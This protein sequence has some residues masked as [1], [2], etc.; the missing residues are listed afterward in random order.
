[1]G[2]VLPRPSEEAV[3]Q[4]VEHLANEP[5]MSDEE[6]AEWTADWTAIEQE[7]RYRDHADDVAE[8]RA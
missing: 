6:L 8:G 7:M 5:M 1:M 2:Q 4:F 3:R